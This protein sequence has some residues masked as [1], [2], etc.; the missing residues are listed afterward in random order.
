MTIYSSL[1]LATRL[2]TNFKKEGL[3]APSQQQQQQQQKL[4]EQQHSNLFVARKKLRFY[5]SI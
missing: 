3:F 1:F 2:R 5:S 4:N